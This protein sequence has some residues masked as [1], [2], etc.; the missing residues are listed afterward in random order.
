[1]SQIARYR[2]SA[3]LSRGL[4]E[5]APACERN[6]WTI[7]IVA[8][9]LISISAY[10]WADVWEARLLFGSVFLFVALVLM[11]GCWMR[12]LYKDSLER[13]NRQAL[14][15]DRRGNSEAMIEIGRD[16][17]REVRDCDPEESVP[18]DSPPT[19]ESLKI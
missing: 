6:C 2:A 15:D 8:A 10:V 14:R 19:Y 7:L 17:H 4:E 16:C 3:W 5:D 9:L 12:S 11:F 1:M 18:L 13:R